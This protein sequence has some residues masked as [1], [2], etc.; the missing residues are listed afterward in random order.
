M[1]LAWIRDYSAAGEVTVDLHGYSV[2]TAIAVSDG[3]VREAYRQ[4]YKSVTFIHGASDSHSSSDSW[5]MGRGSIKWAIRDTISHEW[6]SFVRG[7]RHRGHSFAGSSTTIALMSNPRAETR[8]GLRDVPP[9]DY[10]NRR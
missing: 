10:E 7:R 2:D 5:R 4:G 8:T 9:A 3:I 6:R 1:G